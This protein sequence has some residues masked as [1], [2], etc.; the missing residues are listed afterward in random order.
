V[1]YQRFIREITLRAKRNA[2]ARNLTRARFRETP[3]LTLAETQTPPL[4]AAY[5]RDG[6]A[7]LRLKY[8]G[9]SVSR[10]LGLIRNPSVGAIGSLTVSSKASGDKDLLSHDV[11]VVGNCHF[12]SLCLC[13]GCQFQQAYT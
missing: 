10:I 2:D 5:G 4:Q 13:L 1:S 12:H 3:F 9:K 7:L 11:I 6:E 8:S